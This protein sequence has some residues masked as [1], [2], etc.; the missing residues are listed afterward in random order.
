MELILGSNSPRRKEILNF[1]SLPF[2]QIPSHFDENA[3]VFS[4]DPGE[5]AEKL[6]F[7]KGKSLSERFPEDVILTA[8]TIVYANGKVYNKP[9]NEEEAF[10][11]LTDFSG[12][13][14]KVLTGVCV[15]QGKNVHSGVEES[16][17]LF[18]NLS[19]KQIRQYHTYL[20]FSD[21]SGAFA[22]EKG[23]YLIL[24]R[25]DGCFYNVLG[26]PINMT[27]NLL[28]KVGIDLWNFLSPQEII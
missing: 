2:R 23:G 10:Q 3:I 25:L 28:L 5:Y 14:V 21:K 4:K 27:K 16:N 6:A 9:E 1:F 13:W 11:F 7:E 8:D 12:N 20:D 22:I 17:L 15:H 19:E 26:L 24:Q 18:Q